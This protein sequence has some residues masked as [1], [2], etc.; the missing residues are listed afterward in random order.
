[1]V[2]KKVS[3]EI[4]N[5]EDKLRDRRSALG[6]TRDRHKELSA[7]IGSIEKELG[8][9]R[10]KAKTATLKLYEVEVAAK[11]CI[12]SITIPGTRECEDVYTHYVDKKTNRYNAKRVK[13]VP[14]NTIFPFIADGYEVVSFSDNPNPKT[15]T[16]QEILEGKVKVYTN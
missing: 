12:A 14:G 4:K 13:K 10:S 15:Y 5:L 7:D 1:M 16:A 2:S 8:L 9:L 11:F 6:F 3:G